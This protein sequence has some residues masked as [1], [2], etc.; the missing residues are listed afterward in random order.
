MLRA[1][2]RV[3]MGQSTIVFRWKIDDKYDDILPFE[4][5]E[6]H[7]PLFV[8][9]IRFTRNLNELLFYRRCQI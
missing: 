7:K 2:I 3:D 8:S 6:Q 4:S 9:K 5:P 1:R